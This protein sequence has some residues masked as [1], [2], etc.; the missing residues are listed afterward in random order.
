MPRSEGITTRNSCREMGTG[1]SVRGNAPIRGDYDG[2]FLRKGDVESYVRGNAPIRG[3][4]D[5]RGRIPTTMRN[6][7]PRKCPDQRGLRH[8]SSLKFNG[9]ALR[10][11]G[12]APIRGDYDS[13]M[14]LEN[15][16]DT[17]VRGNAPIRGDYDMLSSI[18][19]F[20][21]AWVRGNAPIRGDYDRF[22]CRSLYI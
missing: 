6:A 15:R 17:L 13:L 12:N 3:D 22:T 1:I 20:G 7:C 5:K 18:P 14:S 8:T 16:G 9:N 10:V 11:R 2:S 19:P 21:S 4:Y